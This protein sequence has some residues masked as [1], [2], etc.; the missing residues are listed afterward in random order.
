MM[1]SSMVMSYMGEYLPHGVISLKVQKN[2][3]QFEKECL[4]THAT[5]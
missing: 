4:Y 5:F 3:N 2:K 1:S